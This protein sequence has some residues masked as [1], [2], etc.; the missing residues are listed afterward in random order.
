MLYVSVNSY[1]TMKQHQDK[2]KELDQIIW[3]LRKIKF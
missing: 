1:M 2:I 3:E